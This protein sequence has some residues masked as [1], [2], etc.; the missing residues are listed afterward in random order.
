MAD[1]PGAAP[2][3]PRAASGWGGLQVL[4]IGHST[5]PQGELIALLQAAGVRVVADIR[6]I[7]R[8]RRN[9]Q[10]SAEALGPAVEA[11]G[12]RYAHLP[13]L[14]G[15]RRARKD[16]PNA[17][18][19]NASFRGYADH[20]RSADF[21]EG[22]VA[23]RALAREGPVALLCAEAVPWRCHRSLVA[24]ALYAHGVEVRHIVGPGRTRPHRLTPFAVVRGREVTY[25]PP[26][27]PAP[28][29]GGAARSAARGP[30]S[31]A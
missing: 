22:L 29:A 5:R 30:R 15:L 14:G 23:L 9:P 20:M 6:T 25:P 3:R 31:G 18:W 16:S 13:Q 27:R 4:A 1:V 28:A 10:F 8:S 26:G 12:L 21:A 7:P 11:A 17:G 2:P 24:D 19:R